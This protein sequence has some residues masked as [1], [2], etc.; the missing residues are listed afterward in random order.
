MSETLVS[1]SLFR[2]QLGTVGSPVEFR[3][4]SPSSETFEGF[5]LLSIHLSFSFLIFFCFSFT[6]N[7]VVLV[8]PS[9]NPSSF[10]KLE[11]YLQNSLPPFNFVLPSFLFL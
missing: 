3:S 8:I 10:Q 7:D 2:I 5:C 11:I 1:L 6:Q 4:L 9:L